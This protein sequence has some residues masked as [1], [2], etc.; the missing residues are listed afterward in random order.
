MA[1]VAAP[2]VGATAVTVG[3]G[4][5]AVAGTASLGWTASHD[6][7]NHNWAG[8]AYD[9]GS[10]VGGLAAGIAG[11]PT[12]ATAIFVSERQTNSAFG[13][14][15]TSM[16]FSAPH[17]QVQAAISLSGRPNSVARR[18]PGRR[19]ALCR[20]RPPFRRSGIDVV[21]VAAGVCLF[22]RAGRQQLRAFPAWFTSDKGGFAEGR[23]GLY[24]FGGREPRRRICG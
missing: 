16:G 1:V 15:F 12:V 24:P 17:P 11:G 19:T 8:V 20:D 14:W 10:V 7:S 9:A 21:L 13:A 2:V 3:L 22:H 18:K 23:R 4:V 5:L 6:I